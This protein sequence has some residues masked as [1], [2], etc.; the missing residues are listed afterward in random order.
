[1]GWVIKMKLLV[2]SDNH[3]QRDAMMTIIETL[4]EEV[5][6]IIHCGDSEFAYDDTIW[7]QVDVFVTGNCDFDSR[8]PREI[9]LETVEGK[10]Y[11]THGHLHQLMFGNLKIIERA[12]ELGCL[13]AFHGHSHVLYAERKEGVIISNPGSLDHSRG[14]YRGRTYAMVEISQGNYQIDYYTE[15]MEKIPQLSQVLND[16]K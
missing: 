5:D 8:Y 15:S 10:I 6:Y 2:F 13:Y 9:I 1:M 3:Y 14:A 11:V 4:R 7:H 12:R 16:V